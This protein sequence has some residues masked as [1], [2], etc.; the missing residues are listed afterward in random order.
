MNWLRRL[1][2]GARIA[3]AVLEAAP[4]I[5]RVYFVLRDA[6]NAGRD[7]TISKADVPATRAAFKPLFEIAQELQKP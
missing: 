7:A 1:L 2:R 5:I 3:A 6:E 4:T